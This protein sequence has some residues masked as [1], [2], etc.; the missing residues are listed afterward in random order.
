MKKAL[1][2]IL[3]LSVLITMLVILPI[4]AEA[5]K[6]GDY[7]YSVADGKA[8]I[9]GYTGTASKLEIPSKIDGIPVTSIGSEAFKENRSITNIALPDSVEYIGEN[10]FMGCS[11]LATITIPDSVV[12]VRKN[13][14][15]GNPWLN[16]QPEG[17]VYAGRVAYSVNGSCPAQLVL[18]SG[19]TEI[20]DYAF[21]NCVNITS[22]IIP[23]SVTRIGDYSFWKCT[24]LEKITI[25]NSVTSIGTWPF[26][27]CKKLESATIGSSAQVIGCY[28][29]WYCV[30]LES[31]TILNPNAKIQ[32]FSDCSSLET[33]YGYRGSTAETYANMN[34]LHFIPLDG[35]PSTPATPDSPVPTEASTEAPSTPSTY[36]EIFGDI[37][38]DGDITIVDTT[39]LQRYTV[40]LPTPYPIGEKIK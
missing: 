35:E 29:F 2:I 16:N 11:S 37:D 15:S 40:G 19:T 28:V 6:S 13:A 20:A 30:S 34:N 17:V 3:A 7:V 14:F 26:W 36:R 22:V 27:D 18:K 25:P 31:V 23:D 12:S 39:F 33:I 8:M 21:F 10:A 9:T 1:S 24:S 32:G 4:T 5:K 38:G